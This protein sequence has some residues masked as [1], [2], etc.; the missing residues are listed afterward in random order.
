M[1]NKHPPR[2]QTEGERNIRREKN[3]QNNN[4]IK[5]KHFKRF[6]SL[7]G[8]PPKPRN[9]PRDNKLARL[10]LDPHRNQAR[11][12]GIAPFSVRE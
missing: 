7:V 10:P 3:A 5:K 1:K 8:C 2:R 4:K 9:L 6:S 12:C 11:K